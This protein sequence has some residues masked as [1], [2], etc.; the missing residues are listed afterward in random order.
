MK[1]YFSSFEMLGKGDWKENAQKII[2]N[3]RDWDFS[4]D[5]GHGVDCN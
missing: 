5:G 3:V 4:A 1:K 2:F